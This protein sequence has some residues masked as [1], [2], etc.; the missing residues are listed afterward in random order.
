M[1]IVI[2]PDDC[3]PGWPSPPVVAYKVARALA[4]VAEVV[5]ITH[6]RNREN[7]HKADLP[8]TLGEGLSDLDLAWMGF[9]ERVTKEM[10]EV[11]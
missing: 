3:N 4:D 2:L 8:A 10:Q 5:V 9:K 11:W 1:R 6:V 7:I